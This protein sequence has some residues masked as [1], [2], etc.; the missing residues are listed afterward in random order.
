MLKKFKDQD[1]SKFTG[2]L[3]SVEYGISSN[4]C[5]PASSHVVVNSDYNSDKDNDSYNKQ[6]NK[7]PV[8][9]VDDAWFRSS[10]Q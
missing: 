6:A 2:G 9:F 4:L 3:E 1:P 10:Y 5:K 8:W 7:H